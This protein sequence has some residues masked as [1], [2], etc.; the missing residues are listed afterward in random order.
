MTWRDGVA[1]SVASKPESIQEFVIIARNEPGIGNIENWVIVPFAA[2]DQKVSRLK[3]HR[4]DRL[5]EYEE[6]EA[7]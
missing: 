2:P 5:L 4:R 3:R 7:A 1:E 6:R